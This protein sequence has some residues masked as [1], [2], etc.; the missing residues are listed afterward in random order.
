MTDKFNQI[1]T[2]LNYKQLKTSFLLSQ[3]NELA[4]CKKNIL[5]TKIL[6]WDF[7]YSDLIQRLILEVKKPHRELNVNEE[8]KKYI[9]DHHLANPKVT[10]S[11]FAMHEPLTRAMLKVINKELSNGHTLERKV[12]IIE[13]E[14]LELLNIALI[15]LQGL[16]VDCTAFGCNPICPRYKTTG[17][18][19]CAARGVNNIITLYINPEYF[20]SDDILPSILENIGKLK[21]SKDVVLIADYRNMCKRL[22]KYNWEANGSFQRY[23]NCKSKLKEVYFYKTDPCVDFGKYRPQLEK[24]IIKNAEDKKKLIRNWKKGKLIYFD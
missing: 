17:V 11:F 4:Y 5:Q 14:L 9:L 20:L 7:V 12:Q 13:E 3:A 1:I 15:E 24:Y 21:N 10:E 18:S 2:S 23:L 22:S 16:D 8:C 6:F 19:D